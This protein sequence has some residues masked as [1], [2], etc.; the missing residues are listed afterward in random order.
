M[1]KL[2]TVIGLI[3]CVFVS[4]QPIDKKEWAAYM[5]HNSLYWDS[6]GR[7]F[8]TFETVAG[9]LVTVKRKNVSTTRDLLVHFQENKYYW[10]LNKFFLTK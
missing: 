1:K 3:G 5:H 7:L 8:F 10:G 4:G 2:L 9:E 6:L